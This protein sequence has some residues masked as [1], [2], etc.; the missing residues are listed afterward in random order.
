MIAT[1]NDSGIVIDFEPDYAVISPIFKRFAI[2]HAIELLNPPTTSGL[3][4]SFLAERLVAAVENTDI[5][6]H[7][8]LYG[9]IVLTGSSTTTTGFKDNLHQEI[10]SRISSER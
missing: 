1:R 5:G 8:S 3:E 9:N 4:I 2:S 7:G 10:R 6:I